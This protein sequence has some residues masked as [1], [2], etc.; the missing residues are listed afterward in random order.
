MH[1]VPAQPRE[2]TLIGRN[3]QVIPYQSVTEMVRC[4]EA[5]YRGHPTWGNGFVETFK[6]SHFEEDGHHYHSPI[7]EWRAVREDGEAVTPEEVREVRSA[8][9]RERVAAL[10]AKRRGGA[11]GEFRN[12]PWPLTGRRGGY[13]RY[14]APHHIQERA[15]HVAH[16]EDIRAAG[17][18][19]S[20]V[21]RRSRGVPSDYDDVHRS[22][23]SGKAS[24]KSS[25]RTQ[26]RPK[27]VSA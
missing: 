14:R 26:Y 5:A 25:R 12:G 6:N 17:M 16:D 8:L 19:P 10:L 18:H 3:G 24:W 1:I 7:G 13:C 15:Q 22:E 23:A 20:K 2:I 9:Y 21:V 27:G 4:L 11:K